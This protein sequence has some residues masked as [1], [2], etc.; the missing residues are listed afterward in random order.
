MHEMPAHA[1]G[2]VRFHRLPRFVVAHG[3]DRGA[4][5]LDRLHLRLWR[6]VDDHHRA[7]GA[8]FARGIRDALRGVPGA[9]RPDALR[10]IARREL[11]HDVVRAADLERSDRL[12]RFELQ[13]ELDARGRLGGEVNERS[14]D[15]GAIDS[16]LGVSNCGERDAAVGD[17]RR[18]TRRS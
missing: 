15:G 18:Q 9:H 7:A 4:E 14:P 1:I 16:R 10:E 8:H 12:Q 11:A 5:P 17:C 2:C 3:H 6:R 13:I